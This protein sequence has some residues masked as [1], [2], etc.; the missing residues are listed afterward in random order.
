MGR[1]FGGC[2]SR[3]LTRRQTL[4]FAAL[5]P[6]ATVLGCRESAPL[7]V[8]ERTGS[9]DN[10]ADEFQDLLDRRAQA[11]LNS[12]ENAYLADLDESN[13]A[14]LAQEQ[15]VFN[16][17]KQ[18]PI[19]NL[20]F[21]LPSPRPAAAVSGTPTRLAPVIKVIK[22]TAD[23]GPSGVLGPGESFEYAIARRNDRIVITDIVPLS[24][25]AAADLSAE[26][27]LGT[28]YPPANAPWNLHP[29]HVT[30]AGNVWL[31]GDESVS[32]LDR[33]ANVAEAEA[34]YVEAIWGD[35]PRFPEYVM[36]FTRDP[37]NLREWFEFGD[38]VEWIAGVA[39]FRP[40]V[41]RNGELYRA[42]HV[43]SR[44]A[45]NL[46][47][48]ERYTDTPRAVMRHEITHAVTSRALGTGS[49][50]SMP[51]PAGWALEGYARF[52][53]IRD[54]PTR[55]PIER[56]FAA[57]GFDG[58]VAASPSFY[59]GSLETVLANYAKSYCMFA[60]I[61]Q[62]RGLEAASDF[63]AEVIKYDDVSGW[64]AETARSLVEVPAFEGICRRV[65]GMDAI[66]YLNEWTSFVQRGG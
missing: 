15:L 3:S 65:L 52:I 62:M 38:M 59:A 26:N 9:G 46:N 20:Q 34:A 8:S 55:V 41:R 6:A 36:F 18:F 31:V 24:R 39:V 64:T 1:I 66:D 19:D 13:D 49:G 2:C 21:V 48:T 32:D 40:G 14:L 63:Y 23:D 4:T 50:S 5:L 33:Y 60:V 37:D 44:M 57:R 22:L 47:A 11:Q 25:A 12:D 61:D 30:N 54:D 42:Q 56:A 45:I 29:L 53:E 17:L 10:T 51:R 27:V 28:G 58:A 43:S 16:N 35:R 7:I